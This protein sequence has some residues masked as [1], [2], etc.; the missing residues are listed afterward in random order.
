MPKRSPPIKDLS[1]GSVTIEGHGS[2]RDAKIWP[3]GARGWDWDETGTRHVP[4]VQIADVEEI[5]EEGARR[6]ILSQ[7]QNERLHVQ[8]ATLDWLNEQ[9]A[10]AEVLESND[11]VARYN[12]LV[13][14][15]EPVGAL[16]HSTC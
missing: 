15:G 2:F 6:V 3:G 13:L 4:G 9:G 11:A 5:V 10:E 8:P 14:A 16:V 12:D 1:W 7:G